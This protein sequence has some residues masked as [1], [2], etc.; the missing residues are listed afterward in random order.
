MPETTNFVMARLEQDLDSTLNTIAL[1]EMSFAQA[2]GLLLDTL[3]E[4]G[5]IFDFGPRQRTFNYSQSLAAEA[6]ECATS[7]ARTF[8][9]ED[10]IDG[11]SVVQAEQTSGENGFNWR[12]HKIENDIDALGAEV[13]RTFACIADLRDQLSLLLGEIRAELNRI[14]ED[15]FEC[16]EESDGGGVIIDPVLPGAWEWLGNTRIQEKDYV[17]YQVAGRYQLVPL[18]TK[19]LGEIGDIIINRGGEPFDLPER[20]A[21][22]EEGERL[23]RPGDVANWIMTDND[24]RALV[25]EREGRVTKTLLLRNFGDR[26]IREG[27]TVAEALEALPAN[28]TYENPRALVDDLAEREAKQI[29]EGGNIERIHSALGVSEAN[30][31]D[32]PVERLDIIDEPMRN[33]L[34]RAGFRTVGSISNTTPDA[35]R[36]ALRNTGFN[37]KAGDVQAVTAIANSVI[38]LGG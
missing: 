6:P 9:H 5:Y 10:W 28:K 12:F 4:G 23:K 24:V 2:K 22:L 36:A 31:A 27:L 8:V 3:L 37:A 7:F 38:R 25:R 20:L 14:N 1:G 11:E 17:V 18:V 33:A 16:C 32:A 15:V 34:S 35:L 19:E 13:A 26:L 29:R 21:T 30:M